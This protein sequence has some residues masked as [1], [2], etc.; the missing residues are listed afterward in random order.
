MESPQS[1]K[2][3][4]VTDREYQSLMKNDMWKLVELPPDRKLVC[5]KWVFKVK[6]GFDGIVE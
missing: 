6:Q 4:E 5:C 1:K 3:K 2:W